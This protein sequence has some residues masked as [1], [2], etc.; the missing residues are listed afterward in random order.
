MEV[1]ERGQTMRQCPMVSS[2]SCA[3]VLPA[4]SLQPAPAPTPAQGPNLEVGLLEDAGQLCGCAALL[5]QLGQVP[6]DLLHELQVVVPHCLQLGLLQP[7]MGLVGGEQN[8]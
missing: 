8:R 3:N 5:C 4:P 1:V 6:E 2:H 7:L